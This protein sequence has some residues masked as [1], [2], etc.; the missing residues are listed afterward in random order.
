M[1]PLNGPQCLDAVLGRWMPL[2]AQRMSP[3][4]A[5]SNTNGVIDT[6]LFHRMFVR[7]HVDCR[8]VNVTLRLM[9]QP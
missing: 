5:I 8:A 3:L 1:N 9:L 2:L 4:F 6:D 7:D